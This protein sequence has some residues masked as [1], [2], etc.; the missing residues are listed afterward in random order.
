MVG[1][2]VG[3][4]GE[5]QRELRREQASIAWVIAKPRVNM[6]VKGTM[7]VVFESVLR[8]FDSQQLLCVAE[9][10][11]T[12]QIVKWEASFAPDAETATV[13]WSELDRAAAETY[14]FPAPGHC[15]HLVAR[16]RGNEASRD[17]LVLNDRGH[18]M[19]GAS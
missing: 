4:L 2:L 6:G 14:L 11:R 16:G 7:Q 8:L 17:A 15:W 10:Q 1:V 9:D 12:G 13:T 5:R 3:Y 18:R 19:S